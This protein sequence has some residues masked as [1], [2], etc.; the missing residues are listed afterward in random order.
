MYNNSFLSNN[1]NSDHNK[2]VNTLLKFVYKEHRKQHEYI[3]NT[4]FFP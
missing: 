3:Q 4:V 1:H 2:E